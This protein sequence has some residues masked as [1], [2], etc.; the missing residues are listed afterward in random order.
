MTEQFA[1]V[2]RGLT[3][4]FGGELAV[5]GLDLEVP[6]GRIVGFLGPNGAGKSTTMRMLIGLTA[7]TSGTA[8]IMGRPFRDLDDPARTVGS[9]VDGV[10]YHP[11]RRGIEELRVSAAAAGLPRARCEE[12]LELV[13][14][15]DAGR[16]RVG[17]YSLGMRQR[18]GIAQAMLG[19]PKVLLLDEPA[20]GLDPEG[21]Q[22]VRRLLRH[23]ADEGRAVLVSSHLI[24]EVSRLADDVVVI[25]KGR[26]VAQASVAELTATAGGG[27]RVASADDVALAAALERAGGQVARGDGGLMVGQLDAG[28]VGRVALESGVALNELR[29][30]AA[31]LEDVFMELTSGEETV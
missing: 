13:G 17:K 3:K 25:R 29:P 22:W 2:T 31:E 16:K 5:D 4:S 15:K 24:G 28:A 8:T 30:V 27:V 12:V 10:G 1:V 7:P 9:I 23:L 20:N 6:M 18:L 26:K 21:I 19:D 14:L 11:G